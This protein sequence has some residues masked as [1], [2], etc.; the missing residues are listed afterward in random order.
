M[1]GALTAGCGGGSDTPSGLE[2]PL[3]SAATVTIPSWFP[4]A[5]PGPTGGVVVDVISRPLTGDV[6]VGR[7]VTWRVDKPY[8]R[9]VQD[10]DALVADAGW[11]PTQRLQSDDDASRRTSV[12]LENDTIEVIRVYTDE[13]LKGVRVTVELPPRA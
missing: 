3:A 9:V 11:T 6:K 12:Y 13:N 7:T 2:D 1:V 5:F 10:V 8:D 4:T